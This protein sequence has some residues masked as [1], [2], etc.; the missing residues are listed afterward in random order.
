MRPSV[1]HDNGQRAEDDLT[2]MYVN[3][4]KYN[5]QLAARIDAGAHE[6]DL[7]RYGIGFDEQRL[8]SRIQPAVD[9]ASGGEI[10]G[11]RQ[12]NH[13]GNLADVEIRCH[14]DYAFG[15]HGH[16]GQGEGVVAAQHGDVAAQ[17]LFDL[18]HPIDAPARF[19]DPGD[20]RKLGAQSCDDGHADLHPTAAGNRIENDRP[21]RRLGDRGKMLKQAFLTRLIVVRRDQQHRIGPGLVGELGQLHRLMR[22]VGSGAGN[23]RDPAAGF[24]DHEPDHIHVFLVAQGG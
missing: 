20:M 12:P 2:T 14:A 6:G 11:E 1:D 16:E 17:R 22:R 24:R 7:D 9:P 4:I 19:L 13:L 3:V 15:P 5:A 8:E 18:V 21:I 10:V 23:D